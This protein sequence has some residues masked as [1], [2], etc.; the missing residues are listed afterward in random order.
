MR[1]R[2]EGDEDKEPEYFY[3]YETQRLSR[4]YADEHGEYVSTGYTI[5]VILRRC[6]VI[7]RTPKG[8]WIN[9]WQG[10]KFVLLSA[11]KRFAT[12]T[13]EEAQQSFLARQERRMAFIKR[14]LRDVEAGIATMHQIM[15]GQEQ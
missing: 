14:D 5:E 1:F 2:R 10:P 9:S 11:H 3:R 12:P 6:E 13:V 7:R 15:K 8:A 4:G